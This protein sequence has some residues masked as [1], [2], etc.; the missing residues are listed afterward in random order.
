[1]VNALNS[2]KNQILL[3]TSAVGIYGDCKNQELNEVY[4]PGDSFLASVCKDWEKEGLKANQKNTRVA[5][6]RFGIV[7][8]EKGA[9]SKM[10]PAFKF[11]AGGPLGSGEHWFPWIH[12]K[13]L[14][15]AVEFIIENENIDGIFNFTSPGTIRQKQFA[16]ALGRTLGRPAFMP[17]PAFIIKLLMGELGSALLE[18]Q[19]A[20]PEHL[21]AL[22]YS[23]LF[24]DVESALD[25]ILKK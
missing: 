11:F 18:S 13:D 8:G 7:L 20:I 25:D 24:P 19:K 15:R 5:V 23:F 9:L 21:E 6:M 17:A 12:I 10:I 14:E 1:V 4:R 2:E 3:T 16:Q 22:G